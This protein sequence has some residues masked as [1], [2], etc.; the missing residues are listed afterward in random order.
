MRFAHS[1]GIM[2]P[3]PASEDLLCLWIT[4]LAGRIS[5]AAIKNYLFAVRSLH[6][7]IGLASPLGGQRLDRICKGIRRR[8]VGRVTHKRLPITTELIDRMRPFVD[9]SSHDHRCLIAAF[10]FATGGLLRGKEFGAVTGEPDRVPLVRDLTARVD[11]LVLR[12]RVSKA[13]P[14]GKGCDVRIACPAAL[15]DMRRYLRGR[16]PFSPAQPLF[17]LSD[18]SALTLRT[19]MTAARA[20]LER[21]GVDLSASRGLSFRRGGATSLALAGVPDRIIQQLGRWRS[22]VYSIYIEE[23]VQ[24]LIDAAS[25]M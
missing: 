15:E 16:G 18:G 13:D 6:I 19:A 5:F 7:D 24:S 17:M 2:R 21:S 25:A 9:T 12:L 14:F 3:L 22:F 4:E 20:L 23:P 8:Q 11:H 1:Y 10:S